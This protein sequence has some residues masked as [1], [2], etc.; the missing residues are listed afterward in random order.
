M[1]VQLQNW[2]ILKLY[3]THSGQAGWGYSGD[4]LRGLSQITPGLTPGNAMWYE[5]TIISMLSALIN[6]VWELTTVLAPVG[7]KRPVNTG[8]AS[9]ISY[10]SNLTD[11]KINHWFGSQDPSSNL[12]TNWLYPSNLPYKTVFENLAFIMAQT[13]IYP[14]GPSI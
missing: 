8:E 11:D 1:S 5:G 14:T 12:P 7:G 3:D 13:G 4:V 9:N 6:A 2:D 10:P